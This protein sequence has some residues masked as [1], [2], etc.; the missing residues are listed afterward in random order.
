MMSL[1]VMVLT[2]LSKPYLDC[3]EPHSSGFAELDERL[4]T[5]ALPKS[6]RISMTV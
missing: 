5:E 4:G 3:A 6:Q 2:N 1:Y